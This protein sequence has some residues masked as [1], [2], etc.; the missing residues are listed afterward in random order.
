MAT[1]IDSLVVTLGLDPSK[2]KAGQDEA[3]R[4]IAKTRES[5]QRGATEWEALAKQADNTLRAIQTQALKLASI[6]LGGLG[7]EKVLQHFSQ[8][9][10]AA[11]RTARYLKMPVEVLSQWE[12]AARTVG[13]AEG[14]IT[15]SFQHLQSELTRF[16]MGLP[17][18]AIGVL[19]ALLPGVNPLG[20]SPD[21]IFRMIAEQ[22]IGMDPARLAEFMSLIGAGRAGLDLVSLGG[23]R[24]SQRL[25]E[26]R[27]VGVLTAEQ[28]A[29]AA[30][31]QD[32]WAQML[33]SAESITREMANWA[34]PGLTEL[35][36]TLRDV[37]IYFRTGTPA[38]AESGW[39]AFKK[40]TLRDVWNFLATPPGT[41]TGPG[42]V[43]PAV[44]TPG[45]FNVKPGAGTAS[46]A[47]QVLAA[48]IQANVAG[49]D[50]F[51]AFNDA[52]HGG[53]GAHG[54]GRALDFTLKDPSRSAEVA[55]QIRDSLRQ[56]GI[57]GKV[58]DEYLNPSG[59]ATGGHIHVQLSRLGAQQLRE[60][61]G[62]ASVNIGNINV[63]S[64]AAD[65]SG[66]AADTF[67]GAFRDAAMAAMANTG[68][69]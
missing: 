30:K 42:A 65:L 35:M 66:V 51:T 19:R 36:R 5:A 1:I 20:M 37:L 15:Q 69:Q 7:I 46:P 12:N 13:A 23:P 50:R 41:G 67:T 55:Q 61:G 16:Q 26:A 39:E 10:A 3:D 63:T 68:G 43:S 34:A 18:P 28:A 24:L 31:M 57:E 27:Q 56:M 64:T 49:V 48:M 32:A 4:A 45:G 2:W 59:H 17:A 44:V 22:R 60:R 33:L 11:G 29:N 52:F 54:R 38:S 25:E 47:M 40:I 6:F 58:I 21:Q 53:L 62:G 8:V 9:D 14:E